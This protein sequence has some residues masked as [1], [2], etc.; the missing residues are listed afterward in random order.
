MVRGSLD[1]GRLLD[2]AAAARRCSAAGPGDE[3]DRVTRAG[4]DGGGHRWA[5]LCS[6]I[7]S[8]KLNDVEP[9]AYLLHA[10]TR[11]VN[12]HL[13]N[14]IDELLPWAYAK[15]EPLKAVA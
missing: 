10:L 9:Y 15:S 5:V 14:A 11:I 2:G 4:A 12:G 6:L 7:E 3:R 13:N 8:C 1:P